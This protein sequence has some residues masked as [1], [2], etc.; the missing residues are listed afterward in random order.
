MISAIALGTRGVV[1]AIL[2]PNSFCYKMAVME[3]GLMVSGTMAPE[4]LAEL[5]NR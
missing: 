5:T 2:P 1:H 3:A 4:S